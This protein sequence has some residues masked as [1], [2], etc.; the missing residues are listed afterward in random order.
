ML[1][2]KNLTHCPITITGITLLHNESRPINVDIR[3]RQ[4]Q[5]LLNTNSIRIIRPNSNP[6]TKSTNKS[7]NKTKN[8]TINNID[9]NIS[10]DSEEN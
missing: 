8:N 9:N 5:F 3:S 2:I 10:K 1:N 6:Q 7:A 4:I